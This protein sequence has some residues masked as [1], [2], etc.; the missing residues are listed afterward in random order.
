M[1][2]E[3]I[4]H[5][6]DVRLKVYGA[7]EKEL[8]ANAAFALFDTLVDL[9]GVGGGIREEVEAEGGDIEE[10]LVGFLGELLYRFDVGRKVYRGFEVIE[11]AE[12]RVRAACTGEDFD[13][14]RHEQKMEIKA[15]TFHDVRIERGESGLS[16]AITCDV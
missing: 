12:T 1:R 5:T 7:D 8:F 3:E 6:A 16:V 13:P 2:Y 11:L 14:G 10:T 4:E 9:S 15:V